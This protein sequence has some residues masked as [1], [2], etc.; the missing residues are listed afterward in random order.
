MEPSASARNLDGPNKSAIRKAAGE[1]SSGRFGERSVVLVFLSLMD[2]A[3]IHRRCFWARDPR[4]SALGGP[5]HSVQN[6]LTPC[7]VAFAEE[8]PTR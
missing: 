1:R 7:F 8:T 4:L 2:L 5:G 3:R 6:V